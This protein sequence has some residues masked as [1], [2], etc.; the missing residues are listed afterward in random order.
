MRKTKVP[1]QPTA[2]F[3][4]EVVVVALARLSGWR[5]YIGVPHHL[6]CE[7]VLRLLEIDPQQTHH[8]LTGRDGLYR[9]IGWAVRNQSRRYCGL[10]IA[11]TTILETGVW[12]ITAYG[13]KEAYTKTLDFEERPSPQPEIPV[14][15]VSAEVIPVEVIPV[16]VVSKPGPN[17]TAKWVEQHYRPLY[18]R[19]QNYLGRKLPKSKE[20]T[21]VD[22]HIQ[23]FFA[24]LIRRDGLRTRIEEGKLISYS[25]VC[26]WVKRS[27]IS[28]IRDEGTKPVCRV[29]HG[30][31]TKTEQLQEKHS[32]ETWTTTVVPRSINSNETEHV[33]TRTKDPD[34]TTS[35]WDEA[36]ASDR[37]VEGEV[38]DKDAF[39]K[40]LS[41]ISTVL[42]Q[43][44][45][46][47]R[48]PAFYAQL[49]QDR[50]VLE[51]TVNEIADKYGIT[52]NQATVMLSHLRK[53]VAR[54]RD[55][56]DEFRDL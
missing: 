31:L 24:N 18:A 7:E 10:S 20:L 23:T 44:I 54:Q 56:L 5:A 28:E 47:D 19:L 4:N 26:A 32:P 27:A 2:S 33:Y 45:R 1:S 6:V 11:L 16:E 3:F 30:A 12:A 22:D 21:K 13:L 48:N 42:E 14:E 51:H 39:L 17:V 41:A 55:V 8:M 49:V 25:H 52:R 50:F 37:D 43:E 9:R 36:I 29:F 15:V 46:E 53:A 38:L 40:A 34:A 35:S